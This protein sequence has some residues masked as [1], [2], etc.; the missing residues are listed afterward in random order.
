[1]LNAFVDS[2]LKDSESPCTAEDGFA[3]VSLAKQAIKS[4]EL[5]MQLPIPVDRIRPLLI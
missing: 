1:M 5:G 4:I 3:A 2:V